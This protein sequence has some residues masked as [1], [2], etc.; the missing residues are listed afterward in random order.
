MCD[1]S[2]IIPVYNQW[3]LTRNCLKALAE[4][5]AGFAYEV[6]VIDNASRDLTPKGCPFLGGQLFAGK[7]RYCYNE[8]NRNFGPASN[9]GARLARGEYLI[10]LNNDTLVQ[11][12]WLAALRED[13]CNYPRLGATGPLLVYPAQE[14][15][16]QTVQHLGIYVSPLK[17]LGHLYE[18]IPARARLAQ[19]RRFFQAI[20]AACLL[21]PRQLFWQLGGFDEGYRNGFEDVDLCARIGQAGYRLTVNPGARVIHLQGQSQGRHEAEGHNSQLLA[22]KTAGLLVPDWQKLVEADGYLP[23]V[24]DWLKI[25]V[26][27]P[28]PCDNTPC[29]S[30]AELLAQIIKEPFWQAG[31]RELARQ[32]PELAARLALD[33]SWFRLF[34]GPEAPMDACAAAIRLGQ[35]KAARIWLNTTAFYNHPPEAYARQCREN[36]KTCL[37]NGLPEMAKK[38]AAWLDNFS[39]WQ[40]T[41]YKSYLADFAAL[42]ELLDPKRQTPTKAADLS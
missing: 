11:P 17:K 1:Y 19:R 40:E 36:I 38:F 34:F 32:T 8:E 24:N 7:F 41:T 26:Q 4:T 28:G 2:I 13:F 10:F 20:T 21:L 5:L 30:P 29:A 37:Q 16:G 31:W 12:G 42:A 18:G 25:Q 35:R 23:G 15:L 39:I 33:A 6:L 22:Q 27:L 3:E 9:Q 14:P